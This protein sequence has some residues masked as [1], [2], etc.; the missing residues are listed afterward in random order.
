[1][2]RGMLAQL[3]ARITRLSHRRVHGQKVGSP[4]LEGE[5]RQTALEYELSFWRAAAPIWY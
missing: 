2:T 5:D 3:A 4:G 1:M